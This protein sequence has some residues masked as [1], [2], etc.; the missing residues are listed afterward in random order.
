MNLYELNRENE[1]ES[2]AIKLL[3][4]DNF[5]IVFDEGNYTYY[6]CTCGEFSK[7][8][9]KG[10]DSNKKPCSCDSCGT[11]KLIQYYMDESAN[12]VVKINPTVC[13]EDEDSILIDLNPMGLIMDEWNKGLVH[14]EPY[15]DV[16]YIK[17]LKKERKILV[18]DSEPYE[19][20][21]RWSKYDMPDAE[22]KVDST[23]DYFLYD[24]VLSIEDE[25]TGMK[26]LYNLLA[27][28]CNLKLEDLGE[29]LSI[30]DLI[31]QAVLS[32][33][34]AIFDFINHRTNTFLGHRLNN[35]VEIYVFADKV[36][37]LGVDL[38]EEN[39]E[40]AF[41][42]DEKTLLDSRSLDDYSLIVKFKENVKR[43]DLEEYLSLQ[44]ITLTPVVITKL[45][46]TF[47]ETQCE[48]F[49]AFIKFV[50]R[51][52]CNEGR[53]IY[54]V[55]TDISK[56]VS[57]GYEYLLDYNKAFSV[58]QLKKMELSKQE[59]ISVEKFNNI[60]KKPTLDNLYKMFS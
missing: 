4:V 58:K 56:I 29:E 59:I 24:D 40:K 25:N 47:E 54:A 8:K 17:I 60:E 28:Y 46:K 35:I 44:D 48:D 22:F 38:Q 23:K 41:K 43:Y 18:Y 7:L 37:E 36:T 3:G 50:F 26:Q 10:W 51:G 20:P 30:Q 2:K 39:L 31:Y 57:G 27:P 19:E 14:F 9:T 13:E 53:G 15:S 49:E 21:E 16:Y 6:A 32:N 11:T 12:S 55:V 33:Y 34:P 45:E 42:L 1:E 5:T 52:V